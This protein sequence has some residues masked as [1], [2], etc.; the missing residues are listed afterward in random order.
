[1]SYTPAHV[2]A[3]DIAQRTRSS[4]E[5]TQDL[6]ARIASAGRPLNAVVELDAERALAAAAAADARVAAGE[7]L[8]LLAGV[9]VTVKEAF[10]VQ[11]LDTTA[12]VREL[13]GR[14]AARDAPAVAAL[15]KAGAVILGKTNVPT[16]LADLQCDNPVYGRTANPWDQQ[17]SPGGSSG[18]SAAA[19][20]AGLSPLE[21]GSD[22]GGSIRV[23]AA[24]CGVYGLRPS[25]GVI[26]K[27]GHLPWP[28]D[29]LLEPPMSVAGPMARGIAD[30]VLA[31]Q[32]LTGTPPGRPRPPRGLRIAVW[33][34]APGAPASREVQKSLED[35]RTALE[36]AGVHTA[37]FTS[38]L[39]A[40]TA[41]SLADRLVAAEICHSNPDA[42]GSAQLLRDHLADQEQQ[43]RAA[44][45]WDETFAR[46][47]A[48]LCPATAVTAQLH[49]ARPALERE[50]LI[51]GVRHEHRV[52]GAWS[53]LTS[54]PR[55]PSVTFPAG[56][57]EDTGLPVG[58]QLVGRYRADQDL[59]AVAAAVDEVV[60]GWHK[61][62]GW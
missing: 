1:M 54:L 6:L 38:P 8:G 62:P 47:D 25:N 12:G 31:F 46:F 24:W 26:S 56:L 18:G 20:A 9:P 15:R 55:L 36:A 14:P 51:D 19:L 10:A 13:A 16:L 45:A 7:P 30:L 59:L 11:G 37:Q 50:V 17:R 2:L 3:R 29:G 44:Q 43:L 42:P 4:R 53:L 48:V 34:E 52:L 5:V 35:A 22:L 60:D 21:L 27:R 23:P 32:V 28:L 58:L 39:A 40:E 61:P 33:S 49:D 41:L 57:G